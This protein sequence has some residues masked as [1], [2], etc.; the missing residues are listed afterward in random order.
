MPRRPTRAPSRKC[1]S[2]RACALDAIA[3]IRERSSARDET[4]VVTRSL[5]FYANLLRERAGGT[6]LLYERGGQVREAVLIE[7]MGD[8]A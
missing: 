5:V 7:P 2:L 8:G 6:R 4:D 3:E 1:F